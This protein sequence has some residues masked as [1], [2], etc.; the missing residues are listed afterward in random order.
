[1]AAAMEKVHSQTLGWIFSLRSHSAT[2]FQESIGTYLLKKIVGLES[3]IISIEIVTVEFNHF[4]LL[5]EWKKNGIDCTLIIEN[6]IKSSEHN[7]Q[8]ARYVEDMKSLIEKDS[9]FQH[10]YPYRQERHHYILLQL[11]NEETLP[12][13]W[14]QL[15]YFGLSKILRS[16]LQQDNLLI[17]AGEKIMLEQYLDCISRLSETVN[18]F[19][20]N[21]AQFSFVFSE[22]KTRKRTGSKFLNQYQTFSVTE[23]IKANQLE[24]I[25]QK[26]FYFRLMQEA[27]LRD[28]EF[29]IGESHGT[30]ILDLILPGTIQVLINSTTVSLRK[31]CQF[32]GK[33]VKFALAPLPPNLS[34]ENEKQLILQQYDR[35]AVE[36]IRTFLP[37][38]YKDKKVTYPR[39]KGFSSVIISNQW[40]QINSSKQCFAVAADFVVESYLQAQT[41]FNEFPQEPSLLSPN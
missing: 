15:T 23:Y 25:I 35:K 22:G 17:D 27:V 30:A 36:F 10:Y 41:F 40:W 5:I 32:Q 6:K 12:A 11:I 28:K 21:P 19:L 38:A 18:Q 31:I 9:S 34:S 8:L 16:A 1:M 14:Q 26:A 33:Q 24:T 3:E 37:E 13:P 39:G 7:N 4:D 2:P 29:H 20:L